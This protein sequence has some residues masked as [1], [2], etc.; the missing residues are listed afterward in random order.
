VILILIIS[1]IIDIKFLF[2]IPIAAVGGLLT[3]KE[4]SY[5]GNGTSNDSRDITSVITSDIS[6]DL[7]SD[8]T[9]DIPNISGGNGTTREY[10]VTAV[11]DASEKFYQNKFYPDRMRP[12]NHNVR[13]TMVR[14]I[15]NYY[16][17]A[18]DDEKLIHDINLQPDWLN[19]FN[20]A[21]DGTVCEK[22]KV[23]CDGHS[24]S[25]KLIFEYNGWDHYVC[26]YMRDEKYDLSKKYTEFALKRIEDY[27]ATHSNKKVICERK[28][29]TRSGLPFIQ[30][31]VPLNEYDSCQAF[32]RTYGGAHSL[33]DLGRQTY[34]EKLAGYVRGVNNYYKKAEAVAQNGFNLLEISYKDGADWCV[35]FDENVIAEYIK[36]VISR[37]ADFGLLIAPSGVRDWSAQDQVRYLRANKVYKEKTRITPDHADVIKTLRIDR[38]TG[39]ILTPRQYR[40]LEKEREKDKNKNPYVVN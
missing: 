22:I 20:V 21:K 2:L 27:N 8:I 35:N 17:D 15:I 18:P 24:I 3:P 33:P 39:D 7:T 19:T 12:L 29:K 25:K 32:S 5:T 1:Y 40:D 23:E 13:E 14:N 36:S 26:P 11:K 30:K 34:T 38:V 9:S 28:V 4:A 10:N 16:L 37:L 31:Y 6:S